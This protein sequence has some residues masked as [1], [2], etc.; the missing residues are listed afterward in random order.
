MTFLFLK[1]QFRLPDDERELR[2]VE[3]GAAAARSEEGIAQPS[4]GR[5]RAQGLR[6][7]S[8]RLWEHGDEVLGVITKVAEELPPRT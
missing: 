2:W 1:W 5:C 8:R 3:A 7:K 4:M 6:V